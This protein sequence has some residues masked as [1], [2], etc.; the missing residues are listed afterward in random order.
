MAVAA[1]LAAETWKAS[2]EKEESRMMSLHLRGLSFPLPGV[3]AMPGILS[4]NSFQTNHL[5]A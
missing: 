5:F 2:Y 4:T 3:S 1:V